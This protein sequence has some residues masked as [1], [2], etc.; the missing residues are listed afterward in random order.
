MNNNQYIGD[1]ALRALAAPL[2]LGFKFLAWLNGLGVLLV[3]SCSVGVIEI[4][5]A[6]QWLRLPLAAFLAGLALCAIG[7][8]WSYSAQSCLLNQLTT[9]RT[10]RGHWLP[11]FCTMLA[12]GL[13]LIAFAL[14]CWFMQALA[15]VAYLD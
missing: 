12:Y 3:L 5:L 4:G 8:L 15:G 14:G 6:P 7:L 1:D 9:G 10:R 13:S 2:V 11:L